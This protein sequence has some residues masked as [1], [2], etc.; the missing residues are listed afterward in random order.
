MRRLMFTALTLLFA[1]TLSRQTHAQAERL[2]DNS[3][4]LSQSPDKL[5]YLAEDRDGWLFLYDIPNQARIN[6]SG[7]VINYLNSIGMKPK[8]HNRSVMLDAVW[9][10]GEPTQAVFLIVAGVGHAAVRFNSITGEQTGFYP[11]GVGGVTAYF[12]LSHDGGRL[13]VYDLATQRGRWYNTVDG[14]S[15]EFKTQANA[16]YYGIHFQF[17]TADGRFFAVMSQ[18]GTN[19]PVLEVWDTT[20]LVSDNQ[21]N[22]TLNT[23]GMAYYDQVL[24]VDNGTGSAESAAIVDFRVAGQT[25]LNVNLA[26]REVG[27]PES[28]TAPL[29]APEND[30][31]SYPNA[32]CQYRYALRVSANPLE[33]FDNVT[34]ISI[35]LGESNA[36]IDY[37]RFSPDC[38][39]VAVSQFEQKRVGVYVQTYLMTV[40]DS[41]TGQPIAQFPHTYYGWFLSWS[42]DN[43]YLW[44][45]SDTAATL[46]N[47][48]TAAKYPVNPSAEGRG[49]WLKDS[50]SVQWDI[51]GG[52]LLLTFNWGVNAINLADGSS[53]AP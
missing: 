42:P 46:F 14:T 30:Y 28:L 2:P 50:H 3:Y 12:K 18:T 29:E 52:Q 17:F 20:A 5:V 39:Y 32:H 10:V 35:P 51:E 34:Q 8:R 26:T 24:S 48:E 19:P 4:I 43:H 13:S 45:V 21:S 22:Y 41:V 16:A 38:R 36:E 11:S 25:V 49:L 37:V 27:Q 53:G 31:T 1:L 9:G 40:Y 15:H 6:F 23:L 7:E 47:V 44:W 33:L